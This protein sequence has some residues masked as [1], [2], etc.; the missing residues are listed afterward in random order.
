[1]SPDG[2]FFQNTALLKVW[3]LATLVYDWRI[4]NSST[5]INSWANI[6]EPL[7]IVVTLIC[8]KLVTMYLL[9]VNRVVNQKQNIRQ[10]FL[11]QSGKTLSNAVECAWKIIWEMVEKYTDLIILFNG[12]KYWCYMRIN[13][14]LEWN[15][16]AMETESNLRIL[17]IGP[18]WQSH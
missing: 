18:K 1:M 11:Q 7:H 3:Q 16:T 4:S 9:N 17:Q 14:L 8:P 2:I 5:E 10:F 13:K 12:M 6:L 15:W